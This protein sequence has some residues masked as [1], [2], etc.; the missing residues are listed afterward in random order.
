MPKGCFVQ[1]IVKL[2]VRKP[3]LGEIFSLL[4]KN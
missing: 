1:P 3:E 4:K 2:G